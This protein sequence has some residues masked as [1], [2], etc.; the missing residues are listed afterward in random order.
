MKGIIVLIE[1]NT[2]V[3]ENIAEILELDGYEVHA[4]TNGKE[5][6]R[7]VRDQNPD[8]V[9]CDIMMPELDGYGVLHMLNRDPKTAHIPFIFLTAKSE[10]EDFRKGMNLG[11]D[12]YITK[13]FEE[14]QLLDAVQMR[15]NKRR[16]FQTREISR[17][18]DGI[19]TFISDAKASGALQHLS[20][21]RETRRLRRK[22]TIFREGDRPRYLFL[23]Q[24]GKVKAYRVSEDGKEYI[25]DLYKP[26][27]FFGISALMRETTYGDT[28][29]VLEDAEI[30]LIP[31]DDFYALV[32]SDKDVAHRFIQL[33]ANHLEETEIRLVRQAYDSVRKRVADGLL[34]LESRYQEQQAKGP[35]AM[36]IMRD[37]L[38]GI[39]GTAKETVIRTLTDFRQEG[40]VEIGA[41]GEIIIKHREGL[42]NII[43]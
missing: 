18:A 30:V 36:H 10:R 13:P 19:S 40:L 15:L 26:G 24:S 5:G 2:D 25:T 16:Q 17:D 14:L 21:D 29:E 6:V 22:E 31:A 32:H 12:D 8:L 9:I 28:A 20:E 41:S 3:R 35:F 33:L 7:L 4:A 23:L 37:D 43:A 42:E 39:V 38:A 11:A 1:D 27:D 34:L